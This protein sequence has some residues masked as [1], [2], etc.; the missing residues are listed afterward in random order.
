MIAITLGLL[1]IA[2]MA[3]LFYSSSQ[4][5]RELEK[6]TRQIENGRYATEMLRE[7]IELAGFYGDYVPISSATWATPDPCTT[8]LNSMGF[9]TAPLSLSTGV[10]GY[11]STS[12]LSTGCASVL[13]HKR[14]GTD[15]LVVRRTS[16][17]AT[18]VAS[19]Q[20]GE[21][22][23]QAS[24]CADSPAEAP[25]VL[26]KQQASFVLHGVKP[27]GSP[28]TC[29]GGDLNPV[30]K[31][32]VR[33]YF[34]A[35]C[36]DCSGTGD[37][38]PTLKLAELTAGTSTCATDPAVACGSFVLHPLAEGIE[39][40]Q[41]EYGVDTTVPSDGIADA[42]WTAAD[43]PL[44]TDTPLVADP[45][46][47]WNNV[48]S[49]KAF[50][51]ARNTEPTAGYTN[52]KKYVLNSSG[53]PATGVGPFNDGYRRHAYDVAARANNISGRKQQ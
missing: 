44:A 19:V 51:L 2:G 23:L 24:N 32:M 10:F 18:A 25:F 21:Y 34:V 42:Y 16:T 26:G 27:V 39:N 33:I 7:E 20:S 49:V 22:Y 45:Q 52:T 11:D 12:S 9:S 14:S 31:Y 8:V 1:L 35:D 37:G 40:L 3:T 15:V 29:L 50:V 41:L 47:Q 30:R 48:V 36:N 46:R 13:A 43:I 17:T 5:H 53:D 6:A 4:S 28:P 38:I